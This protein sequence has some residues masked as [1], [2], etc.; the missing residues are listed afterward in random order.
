MAIDTDEQTRA[1]LSRER[2][3]RAAIEVAD[4]AGFESLSM[5]KIGQHLGVEAMSLYNHVSNKDDLLQG[6]VDMLLDEVELVT[7]QGDWRETMRA[8]ALAARAVLVQHPWARRVLEVLP[9]MT[10]GLIAYFDRI[11][12]IMRTNGFSVDLAHH[13]LHLLGSR[14]LGFDTDLFD[15][16]GDEVDADA[17]AAMQQQM[18]GQFPYVAEMI[19]V[20]SHDGPLG[21]CD[22]EFEF[23]FGLD[24]ILEG[25]HAR[26][27]EI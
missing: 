21:G 4:D 12:G 3:L 18:A 9:D 16:G 10:P 13:A 17:L 22:D 20:V 5:R 1:P 11:M 23:T 24:L 6:V 19:S 14:V 2:V 26:R 8:Q 25:L 15:D 7:D 27:D